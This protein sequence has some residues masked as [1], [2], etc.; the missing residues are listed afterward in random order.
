LDVQVQVEKVIV[1]SFAFQVAL[2][3]PLAMAP[4][5]SR[6]MPRDAVP[7]LLTHTL[8]QMADVG[9]MFIAF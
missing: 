5:L 4:K 1:F 7:F 6:P 2:G 8:L 3:V 9:D